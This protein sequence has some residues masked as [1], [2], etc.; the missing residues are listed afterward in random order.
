MTGPFITVYAVYETVNE[1]GRL[2]S[3]IAVS[4]SKE[5]AEV[6]AQGKGWWGG[7]GEVIAK[8]ALRSGDNRVF[9]LE[10]PESF[11]LDANI[12][13]EKATR[14]AAARAKLTDE[15]AKLLG[16]S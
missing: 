16:L 7:K 1:Y 3:L 4:E 9:I 10:F 6:E 12:A 2:G 13:E 5:L 14:K 8:A 15:E 11:P